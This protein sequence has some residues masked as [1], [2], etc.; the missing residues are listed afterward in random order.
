MLLTFHLVSID[1]SFGHSFVDRLHLRCD[2]AH[3]ARRTLSEHIERHEAHA[4]RDSEQGDRLQPGQS[5]V[6]MEELESVL[7][8]SGR[9]DVGGEADRV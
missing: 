3:L 5:D 6:S 8:P 2:L 1:L 4:Q 9:C 7:Y